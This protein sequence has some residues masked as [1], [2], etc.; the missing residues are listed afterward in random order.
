M[1]PFHLDKIPEFHRKRNGNEN[2]MCAKLR[3]QAKFLFLNRLSKEQ[4]QNDELQQLWILLEKNVHTLSNDMNDEQ[5]IN[6]LEFNQIRQ[7]LDQDSKLRKYFQAT[8]FFKLLG[9]EHNQQSSSNQQQLAIGKISI[10]T[11]FR[12]VMRKIWLQQAR[13]SLSFCDSSATGY[14]TELDLENYI[15]QLIPTLTKLNNMD[16][17]YYPFYICVA[18]RKFFFILDPHKHN[19][20]RIIDILFSG[21][22]DDLLELRNDYP[23]DSS[24]QQQQT[25][26]ATG[27]RNQTID[28]FKWFSAA[29]TIRLYNMYLE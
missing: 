10:L 17:S 18:T 19:R 5:T 12:Y 22:L 9:G 26:M 24:N 14:L 7:Q 29:N 3:E 6:Y 20:I 2:V 8:I 13:I 27:N 4:I 28:D 16:K 1:D 23:K 25:K 21:L 11:F 15:R